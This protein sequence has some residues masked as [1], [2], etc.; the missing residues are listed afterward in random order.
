MPMLAEVAVK[1]YKL[2]IKSMSIK[3]TVM[4]R[5]GNEN[6]RPVIVYVSHLNTNFDLWVTP[7]LNSGV[8]SL[9]KEDDLL[10]FNYKQYQQML[11]QWEID[12]LVNVKKR[13]EELL[14]EWL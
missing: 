5:N 11:W 4:I 12:N 8:V 6:A 3:N 10:P 1:F 9:A 14:A 13:Y 7:E 2:K